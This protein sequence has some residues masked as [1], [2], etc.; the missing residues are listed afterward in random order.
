MRLERP[1]TSARRAAFNRVAG[2]GKLRRALLAYL[3]FCSVEFAAW[4]AVL[5]YAMSE[6]DATTVA[7]V[8]VVQLVPAA[9]L[10]PVLASRLDR[11]RR[12]AVLPVAYGA[13][14]TLL[15]AT[16]VAMVVGLALPVVVGMSMLA[17]VVIALGRP[18]HFSIIPRL[19]DEPEDLVAANVVSTSADAMGTLLGPGMAGLVMALA[20]P[21]F[22]VLASA[23]LMALGLAMVV[24]LRIPDDESLAGTPGYGLAERVDDEPT[25]RVATPILIGAMLGVI[26]GASDVLIV[27][28]ALDILAIGDAGAGY[29]NAALGLGGVLG[30]V[31]AAS[32]VGARRLAP[33]LVLGAAVAATAMALI[34]VVP[35]APLLIGVLGLGY[36]VAEVANRTLLQRTAPMKGLGAAFGRLE[37]AMLLGLAV[38]SMASPFVIDRVGGEG[39]FGVFGLLFFVVVVRRWGSLR[40]ADTAFEVPMRVLEILRQATMFAPLAPPMIERLARGGRLVTVAAGV[41]ILTQGERGTEMYVIGEGSV[42]VV[43][44]SVAL[45]SLEPGDV[46]GEIALLTDAPRNATVL[47]TVPTTVVRLEREV[48]MEA[49]AANR[50]SRR[51]L[52]RLAASRMSRG[53]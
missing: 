3:A 18:A 8:A 7:I 13:V 31:V 35:V 25:T 52:G 27:V 29:L 41:P 49:L 4:V 40:R 36:S 51:A 16:A 34:S 17:T 38:G 10:A 48:V 37:G 53:N 30:S 28:L 21:G 44:D 39:A 9:L 14:T 6:G 2:H 50:G 15:T 22:A 20:S 46:F 33:A 32:L 42:S 23:V 26:A 11:L 47:A 43:R 5:V 24:S 1:G 45:R 12:G 19:V